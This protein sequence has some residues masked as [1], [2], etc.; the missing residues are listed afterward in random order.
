VV[1]SEEVF[2]MKT[3][4]TREKFILL[5]AEG[6]SFDSI[7]KELG[8]S[9]PTLIKWSQKYEREI[10]NAQYFVF[11]NLIEEYKV[12]KQERIFH[13]VKQLRKIYDALE[14]KDYNELSVKELVL[15]KE[16]KENELEKLSTN[17]EYHT[18]KFIEIEYADSDLL[19]YP[20][21]SEVTIRL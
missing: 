18:G 9:K 17:F 12:T 21:K 5:R 3:Q 2:K 16:K 1:F 6:R 19:H 11:Q 15:L 14:K 13:L 20:K 8:V 7:A 4:E 10:N